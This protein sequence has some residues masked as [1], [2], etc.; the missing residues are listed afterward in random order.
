[1]VL[2]WGSCLFWH[3]STSQLVVAIIFSAVLFALLLLTWQ[4]YTKLGQTYTK[5]LP[6][7]LRN[8]FKDKNKACFVAVWLIFCGETIAFETFA[9]SSFNKGFNKN[10]FLYVMS[11]AVGIG[12][13]VAI[14][15]LFEVTFEEEIEV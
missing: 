9:W 4:K 3:E 7:L 2:W 12:V 14:N 5:Q 6:S 10:I 13:P 15:D 8:D 11:S 1:M